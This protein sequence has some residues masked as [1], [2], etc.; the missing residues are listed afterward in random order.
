[1]SFFNHEKPEGVQYASYAGGQRFFIKGYGLA[2]E[3]HRN[4]IRFYNEEF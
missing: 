3:A 1:M 2:D 4:V